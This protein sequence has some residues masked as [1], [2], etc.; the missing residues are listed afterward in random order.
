M[1]STRGLLASNLAMQWLDHQRKYSDRVPQKRSTHGSFQAGSES[2]KSLDSERME[3][4]WVT[5]GLLHTASWE[6]QGKRMGE[7]RAKL[8]DSRMELMTLAWRDKRAMTLEK[9]IREV[10]QRIQTFQVMLGEKMNEMDLLLHRAVEGRKRGRGGDAEP[11][12]PGN[13]CPG[14]DSGK[15]P[16]TGGIPSENPERRLDA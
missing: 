15:A 14:S 4:I 7:I 5:S 13:C 1:S 11:E 12:V 6:S 10:S 2:V 8:R 16:E 3:N 9:K